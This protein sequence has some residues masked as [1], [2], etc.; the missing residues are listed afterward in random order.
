[1]IRRIAAG[2]ELNVF[3]LSEVRRSAVTANLGG[4]AKP[5]R[6]LAHC[7]AKS[8]DCLVCTSGFHPGFQ[9]SQHQ[10]CLVFV[11]LD[12]EGLGQLA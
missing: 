3:G 9:V 1:V 10:L 6:R 7:C 8:A 2:I 4:G 5:L 12:D 11:Q